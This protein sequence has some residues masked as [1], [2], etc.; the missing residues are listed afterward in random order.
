M[1]IIDTGEVRECSLCNQYHHEDHPLEK[2]NKQWVK[3]AEKTNKVYKN[4]SEAAKKA[5][6]TKRRHLSTA[7]KID[8]E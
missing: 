7:R 6:K 2:L 3:G 8:K 1:N 5:W 4:R